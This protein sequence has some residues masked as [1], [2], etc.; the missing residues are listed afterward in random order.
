M[1]EDDN[2]HQH[3][4]AIY[5]AESS[6]SPLSSFPPETFERGVSRAQDLTFDYA[7]PVFTSA[8]LDWND[9]QLRHLH[10]TDAGH[11]FTN[12]ALLISDQCPFEI[13][14][15]V[16][17][18]DLKT[19]VTQRHRF[20]GSLLRQTNEAMRTLNEHNE[21]GIWPA[22][23]LREALINAVMHRN[24]AMRGPTLVSKFASRIEIVSLGGLVAG[25][26]VNDLLNGISEARNPE[27]AELFSLLGLSENIGTGV[28][29]ILESYVDSAASPQLRVGP[30]SLAIV[31]PRPVKD[32]TMWPQPTFDDGAGSVGDKKN[33]QAAEADTSTQGDTAKRYEFPTAHPYT[34]DNPA[35]ALAGSRVIGVAPLKTLVLASSRAR[36]PMDATPG[37]TALPEYPVKPAIEEVALHLFA[38]RG[39]QLTRAQVSKSL[40]LN[41]AQT[42]K[43]LHKL[44]AQGKISQVE[45]ANG[46]KYKL[47][48]A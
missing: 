2:R 32:G 35:A 12:L 24:Y 10:M 43:L 3:D 38:N 42:A 45:H 18:D 40:G 48:E 30:S 6:T 44:T 37:K 20:T 25:L 41:K 7:M 13:R 33:D 14:Y 23:A 47:S 11:H 29:R 22:S 21:E 9:E 46:T 34:T 4:D 31:L 26:E 19:T 17:E 36:T 27:L 15:T 16:F 39:I 28:Q 5:N 8:G 1:H